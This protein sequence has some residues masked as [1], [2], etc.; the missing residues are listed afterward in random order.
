[1]PDFAITEDTFHI[2]FLIVISFKK[3][4][5]PWQ[6][7]YMCRSSLLERMP[8]LDEAS[9]LV[10]RAASTQATISS[11]K[12]S[13]VAPGDPLKL[14]N[15]VAKPPQ[16]PLADLLDLSSDDVPVTSSAPAA[17][18]NDFLQDLLGIGLVDSSPAGLYYIPFIRILFCFFSAST[19]KASYASLL[20]GL[21]Q[22]CML[23][24]SY[25]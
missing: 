12:P 11:V 10:K 7:W 25:K 14:P 20:V 15:G 17:S 5:K 13:A 16:A 23:V 22:Q 2:T 24:L 21:G 8:V 1:M 3:Y 9:Y 19:S 4:F 18:P 6:C